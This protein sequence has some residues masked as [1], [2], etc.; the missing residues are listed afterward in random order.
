MESECRLPIEYVSRNRFSTEE[1]P[2][3]SK[4]PLMYVNLPTLTSLNLGRSIDDYEEN[5]NT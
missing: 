5:N 1:N 3:I 4:S 2:Q